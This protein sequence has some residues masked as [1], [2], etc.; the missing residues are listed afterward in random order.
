MSNDVDQSSNVCKGKR[1]EFWMAL[2]LTGGPAASEC[3]QDLIFTY[4]EAIAIIYPCC[5]ITADA[6]TLGRS[7]TEHFLH[8]RRRR[9]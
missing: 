9:L 3:I 5:Q 8:G 6:S 4:G 7:T 1:Q 2:K